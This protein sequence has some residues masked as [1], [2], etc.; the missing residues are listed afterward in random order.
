[1][2][3]A[4]PCFWILM[5]NRRT[6]DYVEILN[7]LK[8]NFTCFKPK[9]AMFDYE[10]AMTNAMQLVYPEV[11]I[12]HCFFHYSQ[13]LMKKAQSLSIINKKKHKSFYPERFI[14]IRKLTLLALLPSSY[15]SDKFWL[16]EIKA[17]NFSVFNLNNRT[18]NFSESYNKQLNAHLGKKPHINSFISNCC[19]KIKPYKDVDKRN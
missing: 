12:S 6:S 15:I 18:N 4:I 13:T 3:N 10:R 1:M 17:E 5:K 16:K 11:Q 8:Y 7:F 14:V 19:V 2:R 9:L